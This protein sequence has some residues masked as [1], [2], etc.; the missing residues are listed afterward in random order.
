MLKRLHPRDRLWLLADP[1]LD[2]LFIKCD[3]HISGKIAKQSLIE[4]VQKN[5]IDKYPKFSW[6]IAP[7]GKIQIS[8]NLDFDYHITEDKDFVLDKAKPLWKFNIKADNEN[9]IIQVFIHH[10]L[11]DGLSLVAILKELTMPF[12]NSYPLK[13]FRKPKLKFNPLFNLSVAFG[14]I[15]TLLRVIFS[16]SSINLGKNFQYQSKIRTQKN[17]PQ[18]TEFGQILEEIAAEKI[19]TNNLLLGIPVSLASNNKRINNGLGNFF[20]FVPLSVKRGKHIYSDLQSMKKR[21]HILGTYYVSLLIGSLPLKMGQYFAKFI[22]SHIYGVVSSIYVSSNKLEI[23]SHPITSINAWAPIL[24]GQQF[25]IT[26]VSYNK[27]ISVNEL[28]RV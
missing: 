7:T 21:G 28:N 18:M 4:L 16:K 2:Q 5:I 26:L 19:K 25:S 14:I 8:H 20:A 9:S 3:L 22:S 12:K 6:Q 24:D 23:L 11:V 1:Q 10:C 17:N 27:Q 15:K 13:L